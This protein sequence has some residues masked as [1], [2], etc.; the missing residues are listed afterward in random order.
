MAY[1]RCMGNGGST[2][3]PI[4]NETVSEYLL[5]AYQSMWDDGVET[6]DSNNYIPMAVKNYTNGEEYLEYHQP[7]NG[8]R[9]GYFEVK[10]DF[11][12]AI[13]PFVENQQSS[14]SGPNSII[15]IHETYDGNTLYNVLFIGS[16]S[17]HSITGLS[18]LSNSGIDNHLNA[19]YFPLKTGNIVDIIPTG[20]KGYPMQRI[21]FYKI[22]DL[23]NNYESFINSTIDLSDTDTYENATIPADE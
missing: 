23:N 13:V 14:G 3:T 10:K 6:E 9:S 18:A 16:N 8:Y 21:K 22:C 19:I 5:Y 20:G 1:Y 4:V 15:S 7:E 12:A 2:P 17:A 11:L